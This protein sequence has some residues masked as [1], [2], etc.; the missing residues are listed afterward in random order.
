MGICKHRF[1]AHHPGEAKISKFN[2]IISVQ[3]D[4]ARFQISVKNFALFPRMTDLQCLQ[5]LA[6]N[7]PNHVFRQ[8][9]LFFFTVTNHC[10][11]VTTLTVLHHYE[12]LGMISIDY[13]VVVPNYVWVVKLPQNIYL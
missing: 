1:I 2:I 6:Q 10:C 9:I 4:V 5:D 11:Y 12:N 8:L 13:P 7:N 3:K